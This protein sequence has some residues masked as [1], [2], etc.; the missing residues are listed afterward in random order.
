MQRNSINI[1]NMLLLF[2]SFRYSPIHFFW[3]CVSSLDP[4]FPFSRCLFLYREKNFF[5]SLE[6]G[7]GILLI[8]KSEPNWI[9][10]HR[11]RQNEAKNPDLIDFHVHELDL[12]CVKEVIRLG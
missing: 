9:G 7:C 6:S 3:H 4:V 10:W 12:M 8:P 1:A 11:E 5:I 2:F